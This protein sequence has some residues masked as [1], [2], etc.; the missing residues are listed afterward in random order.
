M[1]EYNFDKNGPVDGAKLPLDFTSMVWKSN[2][3]MAAVIKDNVAVIAYCVA[4]AIKS[5]CQT[6]RK[7]PADTDCPAHVALTNC[8]EVKDTK[9]SV[10]AKG[11]CDNVKP[12]KCFSDGYNTCF[13][14]EQLKV[15]NNYRLEH[16]D[17]TKALTLNEKAAAFLHTEINKE[18][19]KFIQTDAA[20][21]KKPSD[22]AQKY[23][24]STMYCL[25]TV[26]E[27]N[28]VYKN[29]KV[30]N[31]KDDVCGDNDICSLK[32]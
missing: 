12:K 24:A 7:L 32:K 3:K 15:V 28:S 13:N 18:N 8:V 31:Y 9:C 17:N 22:K 25:Q 21:C 14:N 30:L 16:G 27:D 19:Y 10:L 5:T 23:N 2:T 26:V 20:T 11:Y 1:K 4:P 6:C 29:C